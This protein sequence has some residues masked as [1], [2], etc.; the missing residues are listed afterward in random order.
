MMLDQYQIFLHSVLTRVVTALKASAEFAQLSSESEQINCSSS[1]TQHWRKGKNL[2]V[3]LNS[4][5]IEFWKVITVRSYYFLSLF[6]QCSVLSNSKSSYYL[7][8]YGWFWHENAA[9]PPSKTW[10]FQLHVSR[11]RFFFLSLFLFICMWWKIEE[12]IWKW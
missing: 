3:P 2:K 4:G 7:G 12:E 8:F 10:G 6:L 1:S 5:T 9:H 11:I